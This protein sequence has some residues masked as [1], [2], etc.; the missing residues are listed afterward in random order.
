M[1]L[2]IDMGNTAAVLGC[3]DDQKIYFTEEL[4]TDLSKSPLEYAMG[5]KTVLELYNIDSDNISG[6]IISCV[7]PSLQQV[8]SRAVQKIINKAPLIVGP[9]LKTGLNI[10]MD[11]A[12]EMGSDLIVD[13]VAGINRYGAPLIIIDM[14]TA[15]TISVIDKDRNYIGGAITP[16]VNI[17]MNALSSNA[18]QLFNVGLQAPSRVIGKNTVE[19]MQS[20]IILG[21]ASCIDGMIDRIEDE[22]GYRTTVVATGGLSGIVIPYCRHDIIIE[23]RLLLMGLKLLYD[24]NA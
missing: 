16:G 14:G 13:S 18:A 10:K 4:S 12:R 1:I 5:I 11:N 19:C 3:I 24:K 22:L 9:G 7:V 23:P 21:N 2:A 8:I 17:A 15:T 6:A 20:G